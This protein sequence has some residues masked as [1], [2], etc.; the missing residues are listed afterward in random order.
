[1]QL[2]QRF[3]GGHL[4]R[5]VIQTDAENG[6]ILVHGNGNE[7]KGV[8]LLLPMLRSKQMLLLPLPAAFGKAG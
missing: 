5:E 3:E 2:L 8:K 6:L 7:P 1:M 4:P